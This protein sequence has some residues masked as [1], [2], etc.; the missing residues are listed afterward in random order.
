MFWEEEDWGWREFWENVQVVGVVDLEKFWG[1]LVQLLVLYMLV[2]DAQ[3]IE[4]WRQ[5][6][7]VGDR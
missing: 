5:V 2:Q 6:V 7:L 4:H 1:Q 3:R